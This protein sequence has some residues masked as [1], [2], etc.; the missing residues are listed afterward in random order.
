MLQHSGTCHMA[1]AR[2]V[3]AT[4]ADGT[5]N[6]SMRVFDRQGTH[7][8][9]PWLITYSGPDALEWWE[10]EGRTLE[11]GDTVRVDLQRA[12]VHVVSR[13]RHGATS[14]LQAQVVRLEIVARARKQEAAA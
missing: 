4:A 12:R 1:K 3:V 9:E 7:Q 10:R 8:V 14:E 5:W 11:P 6:V 2:P 13:D